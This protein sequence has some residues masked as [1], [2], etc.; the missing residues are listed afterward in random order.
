MPAMKTKRRNLD[1]WFL[2]TGLGLIMLY[3]VTSAAQAAP[4][5]RVEQQTFATPEAAIEAL[6][7]A[8]RNGTLAKLRKVL[9]PH[10]K[11]L[12][13]S[14]DSAADKEGRKE[15][16]DAYAAAHRLESDGEDRRI[17]VV[18]KEEWPYPIPLV[19]EGDGWRFDSSAG[20]EEV[21]N[22]RIGRNE[23]NVIH[24]C[25][26]YVEA[27]REF[28]ERN[29]Q[30]AGKLEYARRLNSTRDKRD[31]L[32]WPAKPGAEE[33]PLGPL[34]A[35]AEVD[36]SEKGAVQNKQPYYGYFYKVLTG[37]GA[38][39]SG[40]AMRYIIDNRMVKGFALIAFPAHYGDSGVKTF[41]V[42]Q[43]GIVFEKDIGPETAEIAGQTTKYDPDSTWKM[44]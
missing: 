17:L 4:A 32:Y 18:G 21:L 33:S 40:G 43:D 38:N 5:A 6:V 16:L 9:G 37:Q 8:T 13:F 35:A 3:L 14:G 19:R 1:L 27:Q 22:R 34:I 23:L 28:A 24:V 2:R 10:C 29:H 36:G 7:V 41:I 30:S 31:G 11:K 25:R 44:P 39:A 26:I 12:V 42:N 20:E 15:F